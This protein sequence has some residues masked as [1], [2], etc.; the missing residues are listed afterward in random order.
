MGLVSIVKIQKSITEALSS[1]IELAGGLRNFVS[2]GDSVMLKPNLNGVEGTTD[3]RLCEA[4]IRYLRDWGVKRLA[5][6]ESSFGNA[7]LTDKFFKRTGYADLAQK[8]GIVLFN[9]NN[10]STVGIEVKHPFLL[11]KVRVA[12]EVLEFDKI[13]NIPV[14]KVHYATGVTL[15]LKNLKGLLVGNDKKH[16][17]EIGHLSLYKETNNI[18]ESR[19]NVT[20]EKIENVRHQFKRA[21]MRGIIPEKVKIRNINACSACMNALL[22][23]FQF[24][25]EP[26]AENIN[27][28][29]G[30]KTADEGAVQPEIGFGNCCPKDKEYICR[31]PGCPPYPLDLKEA[32]KKSGFLVVHRINA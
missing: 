24:I 9:L 10:S 12:K 8:Y 25:D 2:P 7:A 22:L 4:L 1:A 3:I 16:F 27:I 17:H 32:L 26:I 11:E 23:S 14:M 13:I 15:A 5:I 28:Q 31:I 19:I 6:G 29:L 18:D 21:E 30:V 20:G